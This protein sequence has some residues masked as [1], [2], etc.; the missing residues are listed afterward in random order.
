MMLVITRTNDKNYYDLCSLE[1]KINYE[2][3]SFL[4]KK[5]ENDISFICEVA[6]YYLKNTDDELTRIELVIK[7]ADLTKGKENEKY[8]EYDV[9]RAAS[10]TTK[11]IQI[12]HLRKRTQ[13]Q[14]FLQAP[15]I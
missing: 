2:F 5:F 12:V 11:M 9:I 13:A 14:V 10:F 6:D 4:I 1:L 15:R 8:H 3:V 7:M